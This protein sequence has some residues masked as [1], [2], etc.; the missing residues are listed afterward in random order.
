MKLPQI[1]HP[2]FSITIP[3]SKK[4]VRY[5]PFLVKE[6]KI[7]LFAQ[8]SDDPKDMIAAIKQII[9][10]C[11]VTDNLDV[12][13]LTT[14]DIEYFFLQLR[15]KS[16]NDQVKL[17]YIDNEDKKQY[18]FEINLN[19]VKVIYPE[20]HNPKIVVSEDTTI[21]LREPAFNVLESMS[22]TTDNDIAFEAIAKC[23]ETIVS[24]GQVFQTADF[25]AEEVLEFVQGL[26]VLTFQK[27]QKFFDTMPKVEFVIEYKNSLGND[28]KIVLNSLNDFFMLG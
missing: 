28:R 18:D 14:Y 21:T 17:S 7:L 4:E 27:I 26:D 8:Q 23:I 9:N 19:D 5:R 16:V 10:N 3:S 1:K 6:E 22:S 20:G 13:A 2:T 12:D 24:E 11:V 15:A 25:S